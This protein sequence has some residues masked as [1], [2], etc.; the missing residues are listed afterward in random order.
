MRLQLALRV[1]PDKNPDNAGATAEFQQLSEAYAHLQRH[2]EKKD[3]MGAMYDSDEGDFYSDDDFYDDD[4][5]S[6]YEDMEFY[7][8]VFALFLS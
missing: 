5:E 6:D 3:K 1:H 4:D 7:M 2:F 8:Y